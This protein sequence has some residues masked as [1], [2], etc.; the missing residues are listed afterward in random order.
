MFARCPLDWQH[1][2]IVAGGS[3]I[4]PKSPDAEGQESKLKTDRFAR[5]NKAEAG[6]ELHT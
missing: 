2:L 6:G 4:D 3:H 5:D 1:D